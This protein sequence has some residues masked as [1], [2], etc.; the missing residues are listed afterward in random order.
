MIP[1]MERLFKLSE[2]A[3][4]PMLINNDISLVVVLWGNNFLA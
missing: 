4:I 2:A 3:Y 1:H